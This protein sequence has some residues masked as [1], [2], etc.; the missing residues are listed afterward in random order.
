MV[1]IICWRNK[2]VGSSISEVMD[3]WGMWGQAGKEQKA[4][5][6]MSLYMFPAED[7]AQV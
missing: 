4:S 5:S 6:S 3:V 1:F 7:M 2:E